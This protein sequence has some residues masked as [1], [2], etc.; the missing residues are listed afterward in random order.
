MKATSV[1]GDTLSGRVLG[2]GHRGPGWEGLLLC[3]GA[4]IFLGCG[5]YLVG[6][7]GPRLHVQVPDFDREVIPGE[8]VP[9]AVAELHVRHRGDDFREEG[10]VT[11]VLRLFK[12]CEDRESM[13]ITGL[14][15][16]TGQN[17]R[18]LCFPSWALAVGS[19][20]HSSNL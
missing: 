6:L 18:P 5:T 17:N 13:A 11:G 8:H 14:L 15:A 7:Y 1:A 4:P 2:T 3:R 12:H 20:I 19:L 9:A 16:P 10:A